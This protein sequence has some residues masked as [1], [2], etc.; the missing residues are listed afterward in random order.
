MEYVTSEAVKNLEQENRELKAIVSEMALQFEMA[1]KTKICAYCDNYIQHYVRSSG[2]Y[3]P[4]Y[5]GVC[6]A[7]RRIKEKKPDSTCEY[8][9]FTLE[10]KMV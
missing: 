6:K 1:K 7:G 4:T 3:I 5:C 2:H 10:K 8:F 9:E